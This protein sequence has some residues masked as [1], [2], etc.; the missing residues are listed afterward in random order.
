MEYKKIINLLDNASNQPSKLKA[1]YWPEINY[2]SRG[3]YN[4]NNDIRF[5]TTM[6]KFS[7]CD[8]IDAYILFKGRITNTGAGT[9]AD[10]RQADERNKGVTFKNCAPFTNCKS[11]INDTEIDNAKDIDILMST[12][13]LIEYNDKYLKTSGILWQYYRDKPN[14][15]LADS[16]SLQSKIKIAGNTPAD[17]N[18]KDVEIM[19]PLKYLINLWRTPEMP[20]IHC[21]VNLILT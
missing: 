14:N 18:T 13:N 2:Q 9:N 19:V 15:N 1:K 10:A 7:L 8:Y 5:K 11:E 21:E 12:Y 3:K 17:G 6:L 20:F 16:E 4:T